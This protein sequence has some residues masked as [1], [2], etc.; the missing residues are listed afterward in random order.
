[1]TGLGKDDIVPERE[2]ATYA[3]KSNGARLKKEKRV[4]LQAEGGKQLRIDTGVRVI[5]S[6]SESDTYVED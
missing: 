6:S 4:Q 1:M 5:D 3:Q 2:P